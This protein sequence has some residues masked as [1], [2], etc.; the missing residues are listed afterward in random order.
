MY[1]RSKP[2]LRTLT[3]PFGR[4]PR[5]FELRAD[6]IAI[7]GGRQT[8]LG[9]AEL[10]A[11]PSLRK[12]WFGTRITLVP[13]D[14]PPLVLRAADRSASLAFATATEKAW[15][16]HS[17]AQLEAES[18]RIDRIA[19]A[20]GA[21]QS[22]K[23]YPAAYDLA[24][25]WSDVAALNTALLSKLAPESLE[26]E[27]EARL[28][29]IRA[30]A[31][32]PEGAR[33]AA[34]DRFVAAEL[35]RW[36]DV[37]DTI[38]T[39]P[40]TPEQRLA[41]VVD[42]D[43]TLV[44]AG[45]GS[46]KTSVITAKAAYLIKAGLRHPEE[47]LLLAF[48]RDAATEMSERI[49]SRAGVAVE[50]RTFHALGMQIIGA[51]EGQKPALAPHASD[52]MA[53]LA[54]L[55][56]ILRELVTGAA[57]IAAMIVGWF[58]HAFDDPRSDWD[59]Q[60]KHEWYSEVERLDLRTLQGESVASFEELQ[61]ANWL[62]RNG[63]AYDYEP[64][65][66]HPLP[67]TGKRAYTPDFRLTESGVYLE[68]FGLRKERQRDGSIR[69]V[70]A[71]F[72]D[73]DDYLASMAW[74]RQVHAEHG[75]V[76]I[77]T[78]SYERSEGRLLE[79]LA[80]KLAPH[81]RLAPRPPAEIYDRV[82]EMGQVDGFTRLLGTFLKHFKGGGYRIEDCEEKARKLNMGRAAQ[83]FLTIFGA[84]LREYQTRLGPRIDFEDMISRATAHVESGRF[85]SP[86]RHILVDEFQDIASGRARLIRSLKA[87][88][89]DARVFAVG[90]D[91]QSIYR[92]A[93]SDIHIMRQFGAE[94]GGSFAGRTGI[95]RSVDLGRTFRSVDRIA[96]AARAFVL[97][98][99]AQIPKTVVPAGIA[100]APALRVV[101]TRKADAAERLIEVLSA[102]AAGVSSGGRKTSVLLLGRYR[103]LDPGLAALQR[104][105]PM[106][107][108]GFKTIHASKGL[109]AD[110]VVLLGA[111]SG[112]MGFP[113]E[114]ADDPLLSLVSPEAEPFEH[115]EERRVMY[116][117]MTRARETLTILASEARPSAFVT[118]LLADPAFGVLGPQGVID[119]PNPCGECG[120]RLLQAP[121]SSGGVWYR[122]EHVKLCGNHLP[123]CPT[124][125]T[126]LPRAQPGRKEK[127]CQQCGAAHPPCP[128]CADGWLVPR[129][130]KFG[131]FLGCVR[132]PDCTGK[133]TGQSSN[134]GTGR[135]RAR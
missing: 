112:R 37:F 118:E 130:G 124:C 59:F 77:E 66:E 135:Q 95:C 39:K 100:T 90:D 4:A 46:G 60:T 97:R 107:N 44:L 80:E 55:R 42:E 129:K 56:E 29:P 121:S 47:I 8:W 103:H 21:L 87:Q 14:A 1:L 61:I 68:H 24:G 51:V 58:A 110:H 49:A 127:I 17:L 73:R 28:A 65:Y 115:A 76:L 71:P 104:R 84:V 63:I 53:Y 3:D 98:N 64:L 35:A 81:V 72:V 30:F 31:A 133:A 94:F 26:P 126:G 122:C 83:A 57:E 34:A 36:Q 91:W 7:T 120:G 101:W 69:L 75:T 62:Y 70:T 134:E 45:A 123:A 20:L 117:A 78:Y 2:F 86:W 85:Q 19:Q 96:L 6:G 27:T 10:S 88:Q 116:V 114:I 40:L 119:T 93:G 92:F 9:F 131:S 32:D 79:A 22:P 23:R 99:P 128:T 74:K 105:F 89:P 25:L 43:A 125:G 12:G 15:R 5:A 16:A 11:L 111:D 113:S 52:D 33:S 54:L 48:A 67:G 102:L 18:D 38:E 13:H 41:V 50:A 106:L 132:Y 108:L 109:E 82:V